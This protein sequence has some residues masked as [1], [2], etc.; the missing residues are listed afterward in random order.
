MEN[1]LI[2]TEIKNHI[3]VVTMDL[4]PEY[5]VPMGYPLLRKEGQRLQEQGVAFRDL[6]GVFRERTETLYVDIC[7]HFNDRGHEILADAIADA[8]QDVTN[9]RPARGLSCPPRH[10]RARRRPASP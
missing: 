9:S 5:K 3:A 6:S 8:I 1:K 2:K 7:C 4:D 10:L